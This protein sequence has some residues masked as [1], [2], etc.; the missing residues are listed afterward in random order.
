MSTSV[1]LYNYIQIHIIHINISINIYTY[2][3][4]CISPHVPTF[5][6]WQGTA[7]PLS[8]VSMIFSKAEQKF[9]GWCITQ[10]KT[11]ISKNREHTWDNSYFRNILYNNSSNGNSTY[12]PKHVGFLHIDCL[13]LQSIHQFLNFLSILYLCHR[14]WLPTH[15]NGGFSSR[16]CSEMQSWI[17]SSALE[18]PKVHQISSVYLPSRKRSHHISPPPK[19]GYRRKIIIFKSAGTGREIC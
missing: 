3:Y 2:V 7:Y 10:P 17:S 13:P 18:G 19:G 6:P 11:N 4:I 8:E 9:L 1:Y 16:Y 12:L 15:W 14:V 5:C